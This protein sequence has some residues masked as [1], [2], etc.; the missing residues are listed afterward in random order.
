MKALRFASFL[1]IT[2]SLIA[3]VESLIAAP[4]RSTSCAFLKGKIYCFGGDLPTN[5]LAA[6]NSLLTLDL[7]ISHTTSISSEWQMITNAENVDIAAGARGT[8][9]T[10]VYGDGDTMVISGGYTT[11]TTPI[12]QTIAYSASSNS[13]RAI[14][15]YIDGA[16][17]E[18]Q[19]YW[20]SCI[21]VPTQQKFY[22]Y[23]GIEQNPH[24]D[25]YL[26]TATNTNFTN[27]ITNPNKTSSPV[28]YYR[29]TTLDLGFYSTWSV[30]PSQNQFVP[31]LGHLLQTV[32][33][34]PDS[35]TLYY[36]G[37]LYNNLTNLIPNSVSQSF[38]QA[39]TFNT[40]TNTWGVKPFTGDVPL[41]RVH[42][43]TTLLP[44]NQD[45]LLYG[46][47]TDESNPA[48]SDFCYVANLQTFTWKSHSSYLSLPKN[49]IPAR[50]EHSAVLVGT[51]LF[52][53]FGYVTDQGAMTSDTVLILDVTNPE[54]LS[55]VSQYAGLYGNANASNV[56]AIAGGVVGGVGGL[57]LVAAVVFFY[58]KKKRSQAEANKSS[59]NS[60]SGNEPQE[61]VFVDWEDIEKK[62]T[63]HPVRQ[64][65]NFSPMITP[66]TMNIVVAND[67]KYYPPNEVEVPHEKTLVERNKSLTIG[68]S[69]AMTNASASP[70]A[71]TMVSPY[72]PGFRQSTVLSS[73]D[74]SHVT[75]PTINA[76]TV[77]GSQSPNVHSHQDDLLIS[78]GFTNIT[79]PD[80]GSS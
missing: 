36:F 14:D 42:H 7:T 70:S 25:W 71:S 9:Q 18:R 69:P 12:I 74:V 27:I 5:G 77:A 6:D 29:M 40:V 44:S 43:T 58:R 10:A 30:I 24:Q 63:P 1:L 17:G 2:H 46:G 68:L 57:L 60:V 65:T 23:G 47:T 41:K 34:H 75:T 31:S 50:A 26:D 56:G 54:K 20:G 55:F 51:N 80:V 28:G 66:N 22:F 13:W 48:V 8:A 53:L 62:F 37:G 49:E 52:I 73:P 39:M 3:N 11:S 16:N 33:F 59:S 15:K 67:N 45:V 64:S 61:P 76:T 72:S 78:Q 79:K 35:Q 19:I 38:A 4:R 21:Y 32:I